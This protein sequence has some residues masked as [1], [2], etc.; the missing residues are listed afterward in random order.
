[1]RR[2]LHPHPLFYLDFSKMD[3][4]DERCRFNAIPSIRIL[5]ASQCRSKGIWNMMK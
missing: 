5:T 3:F 4:E 1:M 2:R